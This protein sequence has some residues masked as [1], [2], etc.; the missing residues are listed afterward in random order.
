MIRFRAVLP[1]AALCLGFHVG[2]G[3][4]F[5]ADLAMIN[6]RIL[7]V[8][9]RDSVAEALAIQG[10]RIIA[11]GATGEIKGTIEANTRVIDL[12]GMTAT[13]GLID[14]HCHFSGTG[15]PS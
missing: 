7:T 15:L 4:E 12:R 13:P 5:Q 3:S 10:S 14:S 1:A 11:A 9:A 2:L 8:D 6:G